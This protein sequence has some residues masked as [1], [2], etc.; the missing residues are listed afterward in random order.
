MLA[1]SRIGANVP[2]SSLDDAIAFYAGKLGLTLFERGDEQHYARFSGAGDTRLGVYVSGTAGQA[3][4]T[5]VSFVVDDVRAAV[6]ELRGNGVVFEEYDSPG[7]KTEDG[8]A[9]FGDTRAAWLKDPDGNILEIVG[10]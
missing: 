5:L 9:T 7:M 2:V 10:A 6:D 1:E 3:R 4:H 8:V